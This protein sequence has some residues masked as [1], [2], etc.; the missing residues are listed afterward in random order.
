MQNL[1]PK[2]Q[3]LFLLWLLW[4]ALIFGMAQTMPNAAGSTSA[5]SISDSVTG[6]PVAAQPDS[7][8]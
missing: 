1:S 6:S 4:A 2:I 7:S 8:G 5:A 3:I